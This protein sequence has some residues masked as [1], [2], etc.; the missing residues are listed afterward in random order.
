M[1]FDLDA[2]FFINQNQLKLYIFELRLWT[3]WLFGSSGREWL[4]SGVWQTKR[5]FSLK[6]VLLDEF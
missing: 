1:T 5:I 6:V 4:S 3:N 2:H